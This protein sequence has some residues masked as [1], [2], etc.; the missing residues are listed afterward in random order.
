[1]SG[2]RL[3]GQLIERDHAYV[4]DDGVYMDVESVEDYGLLAHQS[5]DD[6]RSVHADIRED[7]F[8]VHR[9]SPVL[10]VEAG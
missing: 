2:S 10:A 6:M 5:L 3:I 8:A 4:T 1:M 7:V 9:H